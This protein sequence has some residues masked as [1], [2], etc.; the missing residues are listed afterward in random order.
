MLCCMCQTNIQTSGWASPY[1]DSCLHVLLD[2]LVSG[3]GISKHLI[4]LEYTGLQ[5]LLCIITFKLLIS[6]ISS[7]TMEQK[8]FLCRN[9]LLDVSPPSSI[10]RSTMFT[11]CLCL[12]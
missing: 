12:A 8:P 9:S 11:A 10:D 2:T 5:G 6:C 1:S 3:I 4:H 7:S